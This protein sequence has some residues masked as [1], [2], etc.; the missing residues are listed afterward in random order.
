MFPSFIVCS[1]QS[2]SAL[3]CDLLSNTCTC[4]SLFVGHLNADKSLMQ[5]SCASVLSLQLT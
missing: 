4:N 3:V 5:C 1:N 2:R